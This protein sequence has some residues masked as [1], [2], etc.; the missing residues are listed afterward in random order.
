MSNKEMFDLDSVVVQKTE[1]KKNSMTEN[2]K[3]KLCYLKQRRTERKSTEGENSA[4]KKRET[5]KTVSTEQSSDSVKNVPP[6]TN[7]T[8]PKKANKKRRK[9]K[10]KS[11][12]QNSSPST[13]PKS[14]PGNDDDV[15]IVDVANQ[16]EPKQSNCS[17]NKP[18][19]T[20]QPRAQKCHTQ[21]P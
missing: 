8:E 14:G 6:K 15:I 17:K 12:N 16:T 13:C 10:S 11:T 9:K 2:H 5:G 19:K 4:H 1:T 20:H 21:R 7:K 3:K 18:P